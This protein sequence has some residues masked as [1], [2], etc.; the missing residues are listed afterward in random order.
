MF[1]WQGY[2]TDDVDEDNRQ[3][4]LETNSRMRDGIGKEVRV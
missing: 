4:L 3:L 2:E 1:I